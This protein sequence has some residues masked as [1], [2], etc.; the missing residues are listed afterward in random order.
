[1]GI[2]YNNAIIYP[3]ESWKT[4]ILPSV[5]FPVELITISLSRIYSSSG[6]F[7]NTFKSKCLVKDKSILPALV[8]HFCANTRTFPLLA[9]VGDFPR[10]ISLIVISFNLTHSQLSGISN[11]TSSAMQTGHFA[12]LLIRQIMTSSVWG[13]EL[14]LSP[15][16]GRLVY[17]MPCLLVLSGAFAVNRESLLM[18]EKSDALTVA[19]ASDNSQ[20]SNKSSHA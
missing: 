5:P 4:P 7:V 6:Y 12:D 20:I 3:S 14:G 13:R 11:G 8:L 16:S 19:R 18:I 1:M 2:W 17:Q 15:T 10:L 9:Y